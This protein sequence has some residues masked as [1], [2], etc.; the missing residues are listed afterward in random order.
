MHLANCTACVVSHLQHIFVAGVVSS[1]WPTLGLFSTQLTNYMKWIK[2]LFI[3]FLGVAASF[4]SVA[5][6][7]AISNFFSASLGAVRF[8]CLKRVGWWSGQKICCS[9]LL[10]NFWCICCRSK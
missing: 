5:Y 6:R 3:S 2:S 4:A 7:V 9:H 10:Y 1:V 8:Y